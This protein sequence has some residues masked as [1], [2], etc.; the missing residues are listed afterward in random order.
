MAVALTPSPLASQPGGT[1]TLLEL[2][3]TM[4]V[5]TP[6]TGVEV[7]DLLMRGSDFV[8]EQFRRVTASLYTLPLYPGILHET[9]IAIVGESGNIDPPN[10]AAQVQG[11][12]AQ[13]G[14]YGSLSHTRG[15][16]CCLLLAD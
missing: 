1:T 15:C 6:V 2:T 11:C 4:H 5:A 7:G 14:V 13:G 3:L 12:S 10:A 9:E 8:P 16:A